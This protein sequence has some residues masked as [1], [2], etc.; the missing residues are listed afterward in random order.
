M[1]LDPSLLELLPDEITIEA[2]LSTTVTQDRTYGP[3]VIHPAQ[4]T[5][6]FERVIDSNGRSIMSTSRALIPDR[7]LDIDP[8]S[9]VTLPEGWT[10]NQPPIVKVRP[11]GGVASIGLDSTE[12]LF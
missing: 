1:P 2:F 8:R 9:R 3:K 6:E 11:V 10:P 4:V 7:V 12:I 5:N